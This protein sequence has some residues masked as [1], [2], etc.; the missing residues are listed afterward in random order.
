ML[1]ARATTRSAT[2]SEI[3]SSAIIMSVAQ[4]LI[5]GM[6]VGLHAIVVVYDR[7]R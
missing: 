7:Y 2:S 5:A 1:T 3:T 6:S 4:D